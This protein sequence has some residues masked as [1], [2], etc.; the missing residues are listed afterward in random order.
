MISSF[1]VERM[2]FERDVFN[3]LKPSV[4]GRLTI[5]SCLVLLSCVLFGVS[6][7]YVAYIETYARSFAWLFAIVIGAGVFV[8]AVNIQRLFITAGGFG[9]SRRLRENN[10]V[11]ATGEIYR[12][13]AIA[14]WRPDQ[15]RLFLIFLLA[16]VFSQPLLLLS[17]SGNLNKDILGVID[18]QLATFE[19]DQAS[20]IEE[21]RVRLV[22]KQ[23]ATLDKLARASFDIKTLGTNPVPDAPPRPALQEEGGA[24]ALATVPSA[25]PLVA[26]ASAEVANRP[27]KAIVI[28]VEKYQYV[29]PLFNPTKDAADM[30]RALQEIGYQVTTVIGQKTMSSSLQVE[31][32]RYIKSLKPG[33]VSVFY[34]SG[35]G[36]MHKGRNFLGAL[37]ANG[38][39]A[40]DINIIQLIEDIS[41]R[42][43]RA[44]IVLLDACSS[45]PAG[46]D[47]GGLGHLNRDIKGTLVAY[48]AAPGQTAIDLPRGQNGLFTQKLLKSLRRPQSISEIM[49]KV[50]QEVVEEAERH[51]HQ[52]T[53]YV[54]DV[55]MDV[56][57]FRSNL[58]L[59]QP[60]TASARVS[61]KQQ[62]RS[63]TPIVA[64]GVPARD[65]CEMETGPDVPCLLADFEL[66][67]D[68]IVRRDIAMSERL[69][70]LISDYRQ[71]LVVS[72]HLTDRFRLQWLHPWQSL[73]LS[74]F[75][76]LLLWGG[77]LFRDLK[78]FSLRAF[79]RERYQQVRRLIRNNQEEASRQT[80]AELEKF[81]AYRRDKRERVPLWDP[82]LDL[83][84]YSEDA[85]RRPDHR[86]LDLGA[87]SVLDLINDLRGAPAA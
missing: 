28:G 8:F 87:H 57:S 73:T 67:A 83:G 4:Q 64:G 85:I 37:D 16:L 14:T 80:C 75:F 68:R 58:P 46:A 40:I 22:V 21:E 66:T 17:Q 32:D 11:K 56:V 41:R 29:T 25:M 5:E 77:D 3:K 51:Q 38:P 63:P 24:A 6:G 60:A 43:P 76:V 71:Q 42:S 78:P 53:P 45:W 84:F 39:N 31:I 65:P 7:A 74:L 35:H 81:D 69:P 59:E 61:G 36:Y 86:E 72:G 62:T 15:L 2:G 82:D 20:L 26:D 30:T 70:A 23:R 12:T 1:I 49:I 48:A 44:S 33:D 47:R 13:D 9:L 19:Q 79:E 55:L 52:Q 54:T 18:A 50:R 34:F 27:H 10:E